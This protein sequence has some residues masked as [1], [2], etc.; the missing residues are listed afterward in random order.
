VSSFSP[1]SGLVEEEV[2]EGEES[3]APLHRHAHRHDEHDM[4]EYEEET[5]QSQIRSGALGEMLQEAHLD[6]RIQLD[7]D[8][9]GATEEVEEIAEEEAEEEAAAAEGQ[10]A[11]DGQPRPR[12]EQ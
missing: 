9:K 12:R 1:G 6:H 3:D 8:E 7:L 2:I 5:L 11:P 4:D 10:P